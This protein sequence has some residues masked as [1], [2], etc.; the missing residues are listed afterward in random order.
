MLVCIGLYKFK[1]RSKISRVPLYL[2]IGKVLRIISKSL[3]ILPYSLLFPYCGIRA[4]FVGI[5]YGKILVSPTTRGVRGIKYGFVT[6][7]GEGHIICVQ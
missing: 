2:R 4:D 5:Q 3:P 1:L 7:G 6:R